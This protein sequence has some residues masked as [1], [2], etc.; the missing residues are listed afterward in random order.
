MTNLPNFVC[1]GAGKSGTTSLYHYLKQHPE[2]FL[3]DQKELHYFAWSDL[4]EFNEGPGTQHSRSDW[5]KTRAQ[6]ERMFEGA[7]DHKIVGDISPS[8]LHS[9]N[10][11]EQIKQT[12][13]SPKIIILLRN[14]V[15]KVISQYMHLKR[16]GREALNLMDALRAEPERIAAKWGA[17]YHYISTSMYAEDVARYQALFGME[18]VGIWSFDAFV[19]ESEKTLT[20][21][22]QFLEI[23]DNFQFLPP[24]KTNRSGQPRSR[25]LGRLIG[26]N[27]LTSLAKKVIPRPLGVKVK[28]LILNAN[29]GAKEDIEAS[30]LEFL[31]GK[32]SDDLVELEKMSGL[33]FG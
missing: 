31:K 10:A 7:D 22:C 3:P 28:S 1:V 18:N 16:D 15:D 30:D 26:P 24:E 5:C 20:E 29:T 19:G 17:I 27:G 32:F 4:A 25:L 14:P 21:I 11:P 6:Y 2:V 23:E 12:L 8:Y 9:R 13:G 33:K